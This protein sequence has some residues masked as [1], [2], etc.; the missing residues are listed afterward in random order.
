VKKQVNENVELGK[1]PS[2]KW[3]TFITNGS[4][5]AEVEISKWK[6]AELIMYF[7]IRYKEAYG[8]EYQLKFNKPTPSKSYE[9]FRL[10]T[11]CNRLSANPQIIKDYIDWI[12]DQKVKKDGKR[13]TSISFLTN[14][15]NLNWYKLNV[16]LADQTNMHIDRSTVLPSH[17]QEIVS[18][19]GAN[20][21]GE[22]AFILQA[23]KTMTANDSVAKVVEQ[24]ESINFDFSSLERIV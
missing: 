14:D 10:N 13:F 7:C 22:L 1:Y 17:I 21:Y 19:I 15:E 4:R 2:P 12:F 20:T 9:V 5:Y 6:A 23:S 18:S 24:L 3:E 16:L 8:K 11:I